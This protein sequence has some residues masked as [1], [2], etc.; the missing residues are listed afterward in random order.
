M[1][2]FVA[3]IR[4]AVA[5]LS[6][7]TP[8]MRQKVYEKARGAVRRQL[9]AMNPR[10]SD[11]LIQR[12][13]DK[14][15]A[16]IEDVEGEHAEALPPEDVAS[17]PE[18]EPAAAV[19]V[20]PEPE[21]EP[22]PET[23]A[24]PVIEPETRPEPAIEPEPEIGE[25]ETPGPA[26]EPEPSGEPPSETDAGPEDAVPAEEGIAEEQP[27]EPHAAIEPAPVSEEPLEPVVP[28]AHSEPSWHAEGEAA[29]DYVPSWHVADEPAEPVEGPADVFPVHDAQAEEAAPV[30]DARMPSAEAEWNWGAATPVIAVDDEAVE[31]LLPDTDEPRLQWPEQPSGGDLENAPEQDDWDDLEDLTAPAGEVSAFAEPMTP[32]ENGTTAAAASAAETPA[33]DPQ[34]SFRAEPR[35]SRL[36]VATLAVLLCGVAI[37]GGAGAAYWFNRDSVNAWFESLTAS[38]TGS[39]TT[40]E[41]A[42][43]TADGSSDIAPAASDEGP[44][45]VDGGVQETASAGT[46][47][48]ESGKF[49]QRLLADGSEVDE[50]PAPS[51]DGTDS[52][53]GK[54]VAGQSSET[55]QL[56]TGETPDGDAPATGEDAA[57]TAGAAPAETGT[58]AGSP[59][60]IGVAQKMF[61]YE[62]RLGQTSPTAIEGTVAWSVAEE[63]PGGDARPEPVV[64]AQLNVPSNGLTA[65]VTFRR[66]ADQSLPASH[67][68]ELVFSLPESFEGGGIDSVQRIAMKRTEQDRGDLLIAVPAKITDDFHMIALND[69]PEAIAKNTELLRTRNW[70]DIPIT[71]RNGRRALLTLDKGATGAEAFD[72]VMKAWASRDAA[73]SQ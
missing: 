69:F 73:S 39:A 17:E 25:P 4:R 52:Q 2:D 63:S 46:G 1:A 34:R 43:E 31:A 67:I 28:E 16:A 64:R 26:I 41:A 56:A 22:Y 38:Q 19:P 62:E 58:Q 30:G 21:P 72:T 36:N 8:E 13:L 68:V 12:Q 47:Q 18:V 71:Y 11:E 10:P 23:V 37:V 3:V 27:P 40:G 50:G 53:E 70:I 60:A 42:T 57:A 35:K 32:Q 45:D 33:R 65:L 55:A 14:L 49:T 5:G 59:S 51:L 44:T 54:S 9:E 20:A 15:E 7:D 24:E 6:A 48:N 61:L 29:D 66:N